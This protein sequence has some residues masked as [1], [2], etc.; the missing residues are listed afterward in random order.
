MSP[1][2]THPLVYVLG[3]PQHPHLWYPKTRMLLLGKRQGQSSDL[4]NESYE[5]GFYSLGGR[6]PFVSVCR[7][8]VLQEEIGRGAFSV[9]H[10]CTNRVTGE[11]FAVKIIDLRPLQLRESFD[12]TRLRR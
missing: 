7:M 6:P 2:A 11:D 8:Y 10:R 1:Q 4:P 9:V 5:P 12:Q 3:N